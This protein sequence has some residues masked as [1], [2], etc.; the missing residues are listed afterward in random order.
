MVALSQLLLSY[1]I[2]DSDAPQYKTIVL[3]HKHALH[4]LEQQ[5]QKKRQQFI[6]VLKK[7]EEEHVITPNKKL[8]QC[9]LPEVVINK[10]V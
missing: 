8:L 3:V 2:D 6:D 7:W 5:S 1:A 10:F 9:A 4:K